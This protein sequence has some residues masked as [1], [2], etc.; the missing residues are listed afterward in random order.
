MKSKLIL[1][2][3]AIA[4]TVLAKENVG[5]RRQAH[6]PSGKMK[7]ITAGCAASTAKTEM[8][9]NNVRTVILMN[10]DMWWDAMASLGPQYEIPK[11]GGIHSLF[12]G[13]LWMGGVD[14]SNNLKVAAQTYRQDGSD[15]WPG[16]L[17]TI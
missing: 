11:G 4:G 8:A 2:L 1:L 6:A 9:F 16:P 17:D 3:L 7:S 5:S 12:S 14:A 10:G 13:A 15:F